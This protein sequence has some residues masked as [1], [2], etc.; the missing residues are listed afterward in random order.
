MS[1]KLTIVVGKNN[2]AISKF[3]NKYSGNIFYGVSRD[4]H[5]RNFF[6]TIQEIENHYPNLVS[7]INF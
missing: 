7:K 5:K 4:G 2:Y 6:D 3:E 1:E